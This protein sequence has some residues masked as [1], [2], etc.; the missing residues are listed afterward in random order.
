MFYFPVGTDDSRSPLTPPPARAKSM[1]PRSTSLLP[2]H[3]APAWLSGE[4]GKVGGRWVER[5]NCPP[6]AFT[7]LMP[8]VPGPP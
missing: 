5:A 4:R 8:K 7:K 6:Q 1:N 3:R 2:P